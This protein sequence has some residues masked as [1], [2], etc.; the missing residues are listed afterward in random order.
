[1]SGSVWIAFR[2]DLGAEQYGQ[3]GKLH[4]HAMTKPLLPL[5]LAH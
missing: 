2:Q 3:P 1:M 4:T 5:D